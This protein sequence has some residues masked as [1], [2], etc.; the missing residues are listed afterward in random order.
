MSDAALRRNALRAALRELTN[1]LRADELEDDEL[2]ATLNQVHQLVFA[3]DIDSLHL[4]DDAGAHRA[5][6]L[7]ILSRIPEGWGRWISC[8]AGWYP[9]ITRLDEDL[10]AVDA[11]Y[12]IHQVKEKY[13]SLRFYA[14]PADPALQDL[15]DII[16]SEAE[17]RSPSIC[18]ACSG[19]GH[20]RE[21]DAGWHKTL[22]QECAGRLGYA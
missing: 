2:K 6:L 12:V 18:E 7:A 15:F 8:G 11:D 5:G 10:T 13:G 1:R 19:P 20:M 17:S 21:N 9:L 22:C 3:S 4:P 16:I 14:E